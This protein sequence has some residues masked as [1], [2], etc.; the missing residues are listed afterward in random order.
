MVSPKKLLNFV[1]CL[2]IV[3]V[4]FFARVNIRALHILNKFACFYFREFELP[5]IDLQIKG[6]YSRIFIFALSDL[7]AKSA[8]IKM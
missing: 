2:T 1:F 4:E 5:Y 7:S 3:K 6:I 8:K